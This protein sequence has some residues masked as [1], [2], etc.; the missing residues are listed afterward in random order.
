MPCGSPTLPWPRTATHLLLQPHSHARPRQSLFQGRGEALWGHEQKLCVCLGRRLPCRGRDAKEGQG[1]GHQGYHS[2]ELTH[3][4][5][6][7]WSS[8]AV[9]VPASH[10]AFLKGTPVLMVLGDSISRSSPSPKSVL[11]LILT[12][13]WRSRRQTYSLSQLRPCS[14]Y[15]RKTCIPFFLNLT[16]TWSWSLKSSRIQ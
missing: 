15:I 11:K 3:S 16:A 6:V 1:C 8:T 9:C 7:Q 12:T 4:P 2:E 13:L 5:L 10:R 14:T